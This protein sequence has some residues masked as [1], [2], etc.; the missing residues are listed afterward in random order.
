MTHRRRTSRASD[1]KGTSIRNVWS[2]CE[3]IR[4]NT[5]RTRD[6]DWRSLSGPQVPKCQLILA[7]IPVCELNWELLNCCCQ[8]WSAC[9]SIVARLASFHPSC[10]GRGQQRVIARSVR[11]WYSDGREGNNVIKTIF[12]THEILARHRTFSAGLP[13]SARR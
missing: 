6:R 10:M 4:H 1:G 11:L 7:T 2:T 5:S 13:K 9:Q 3:S 12:G 8:S